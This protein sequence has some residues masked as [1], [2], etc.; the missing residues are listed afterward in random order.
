MP[1]IKPIRDLRNT[2]EIS[3]IAHKLNEPIFITKNGYG[4][5]VVMSIETYERL[6]ETKKI[7][8]AIEE[9]E[10]DY[11]NTNKTYDAHVAFDLVKSK[12]NGKI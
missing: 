12:Y 5:L 3:D 8:T 9:S 10:K 2:N 1:I 6:I 11:N 7:D 4:D